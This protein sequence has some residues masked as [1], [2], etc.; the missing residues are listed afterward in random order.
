MPSYRF[1]NHTAMNM[2]P[3]PDKDETG[4]SATD[5]T[6]VGRACVFANGQT[7]IAEAG[8]GF[9]TTADPTEAD[10]LHF[11]ITLAGA[12]NMI[13]AA[14][15][16]GRAAIKQEDRK[17]WPAPTGSL[18]DI[19]ELYETSDEGLSQ[20]PAGPSGTM[21]KALRVNANDVQILW[22]TDYWDGPLAGIAVYQGQKLWF[23]VIDREAEP[24]VAILHSLTGDQLQF[25]EDR[26]RS[27]Q[28]HVGGH[29]DYDSSGKRTVCTLQPPSQW[30]QF[31]SAATAAA[32]RR[33]YET[34]PIIGCFEL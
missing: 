32:K 26:H 17:T 24:R 11:L 30:A 14:W 34:N 13:M 10:P 1:G 20:L 7:G 3:R 5:T 29:T 28:Q 22:H 33:S 18:F 2:T 15:A 9:V 21:D 31:Y 19:S 27:F 12:W 16:N 25:E 6:P 23:Q 8:S 4:L